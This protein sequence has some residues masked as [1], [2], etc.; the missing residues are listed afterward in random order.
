MENVGELYVIGR[1]GQDA[2]EW[3]I[4]LP[5]LLSDRGGCWGYG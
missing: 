1:D 3:E 5:V 4:T 2:Q